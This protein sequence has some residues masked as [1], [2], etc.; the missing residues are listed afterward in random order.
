MPQLA[1]QIQTI[2]EGG[3]SMTPESRQIVYGLLSQLVA[4]ENER[5]TMH[6]TLALACKDARDYRKRCLA[7]AETIDKQDAALCSLAKE[8]DSLR[9]VQSKLIEENANLMAEAH[10]RVG[11]IK[12][13]QSQLEQEKKDREFIH[14]H[15]EDLMGQI[16]ELRKSLDSAL[17]EAGKYK[18]A[19]AD[20]TEEMARLRKQ[21]DNAV[22][23]LN[24]Y[25]DAA[26]ERAN[27]PSNVQAH[28]VVTPKIVS[29]TTINIPPL[30]DGQSITI[31]ADTYPEPSKYITPD[32]IEY[33]HHKCG[34]QRCC[35]E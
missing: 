17:V 4:V 30:K 19:N 7:N 25:R 29:G 28:H 24:K 1:A 18:T 10:E 12:S 16:R 11:T 14:N 32:G 20:L 6:Q 23:E 8:R 35:G 5:N 21:F 22:V 31:K 34:C 9:D 26:I 3:S 27:S 33:H 15:R 2:L 13:L